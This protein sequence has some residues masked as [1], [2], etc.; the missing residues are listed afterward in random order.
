L[1]DVSFLLDP[2]L[3]VATGAAIER[4]SP[5]EGVARLAS[6]A[7]VATV[8]GT[9]V[10]LYLDAPGLGLIWRPFRAKSGRDFML[11][12]GLTRFPYK[13]PSARTHLL[14][15]A[16]FAAYPLWLRAGRRVARRT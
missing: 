7:A 5:D 4:L 11:N 3:L 14:A 13:R 1:I 6:R 12:S 2:P 9:S 16:L 10:A 8:V 15:V